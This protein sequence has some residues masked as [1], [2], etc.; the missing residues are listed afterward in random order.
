[1]AFIEV[2]GYER[3]SGEL[4]GIYDHIISTRGKLADVHT[5]QSLN[6]ATILSHMNLYKDIMFGQSPLKRYQREMMAIV[7][8]SANQCEYCLRHHSEALFHFWKDENKVNALIRQ[9]DL[10]DLN[11]EDT[12]LC[13]FARDMT[14]SPELF[15]QQKIDI[16]KTKGLSDRSV[17][18]AVLV[19]AYFNFVNRIVLGL[20]LAVETEE[21]KGYNY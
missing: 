17:L 11:D 2:I 6:P 21:I 8:S 1:M 9:P 14:V 20:G 10:A 19:V 18:D 3:S 5:I 12:A 16:L 15:T 4:R 7:V 13:Q